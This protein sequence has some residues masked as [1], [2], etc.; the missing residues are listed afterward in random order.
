MNLL[1]RARHAG[2][3]HRLGRAQRLSQH[4][5]RIQGPPVLGVTE[6]PRIV[7]V[8]DRQTL[9]GPLADGV[10]P[11]APRLQGRGQ[12]GHRPLRMQ[13]GPAQI[14]RTARRR[15][16]PR[17]AHRA[18]PSPA[19]SAATSARSLRSPS[20]SS[21]IAGP[22]AAATP[23]TSVADAAIVPGDESGSLT[24]R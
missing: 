12:L 4:A 7:Q 14:A 13:P 1:V 3:Q 16:H 18:R 20:A 9:L 11:Q 24:T 21:T 17:P 2:A 8:S 22:V 6:H 23:K 10:G 15:G 5:A 19:A